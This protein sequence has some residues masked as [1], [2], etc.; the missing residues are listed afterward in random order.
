MAEERLGKRASAVRWIVGDVT[1]LDLGEAAFD[2]WHDRA[3][4]HFLVEPEQRR[5]YLRSACRSLATGGH[6]VLAT[7]ALDGPEKCSGLPVARY[8]ADGL[9]EAFGSP[10]DLVGQARDEHETPFGK[11]QSFVYCLCHK[12]ADCEVLG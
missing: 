11:T 6:V 7:F 12:K 3:V 8:S 4:F 5:R 2:L 1:E 9:Q 10:F